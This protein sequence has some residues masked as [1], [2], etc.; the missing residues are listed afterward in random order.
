MRCDVLPD[1][2]GV[3]QPVRMPVVPAESTIKISPVKST[4]ARRQCFARNCA[5]KLGLNMNVQ[6]TRYQEVFGWLADG[7]TSQPH[8]VPPG[9]GQCLCVGTS[10]EVS[11]E[12]TH[13]SSATG[14]HA[15]VLDAPDTS[16]C[17]CAPGSLSCRCPASPRPCRG[18]TLGHSRARGIAPGPPW[19]A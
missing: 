16:R 4:H 7:I 11:R 14:A 8:S 10:Q 12:D 1:A 17:G 3:R 6:L 18:V 19:P 15:G 13:A 5:K 2:L 9:A